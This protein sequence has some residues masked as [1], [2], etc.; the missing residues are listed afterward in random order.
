MSHI[1]SKWKKLAQ[2]NYK[3]KHD[4]VAEMIYNGNIVRS[5]CLKG[6]NSKTSLG[7]EYPM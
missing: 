2:K 5:L 7:H 4:N 1:I 3:N 6:L